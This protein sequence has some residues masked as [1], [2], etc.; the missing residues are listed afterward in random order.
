RTSYAAE[1]GLLL[2]EQANL[3]NQVELYKSLGGGVKANT[4]DA[5]SQPASSAERKAQ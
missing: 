4:S 5:T 1:Q 3:N 2:L